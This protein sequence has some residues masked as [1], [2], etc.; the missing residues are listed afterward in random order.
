MDIVELKIKKLY[1]SHVLWPDNKLA[2]QPC[3][4]DA[5]SLAVG[6]CY[7]SKFYFPLNFFGFSRSFE[8]KSSDTIIRNNETLYRKLDLDNGVY[9]YYMLSESEDRWDA[10]EGYT[11]THSEEIDEIIEI[12]EAIDTSKTFSTDVLTGLLV[13]ENPGGLCLIQITHP[14]LKGRFYKTNKLFTN[15]I[16]NYETSRQHYIP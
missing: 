2:M 14:K 11:Y 9:H 7:E 15:K 13:K 5:E 10:A 8:L 16:G 4:V 1:I 3:A 6:L 12:N